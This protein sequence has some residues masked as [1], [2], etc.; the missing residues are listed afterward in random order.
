MTAKN[1]AFQLG[2]S[3]I[4]LG[5]GMRKIGTLLRLVFIIVLPFFLLSASIA[6]GFNSLWWYNFGF[7]KYHISE[8][9]GLSQSELNKAAQELIGYFNS[10]AELA[11]FRLTKDGQT[12]TLFSPQEQVHFKDVK[13]LVHL[14]YSVLIS[15][16]I[17]ALAFVGF[18]IWRRRDIGWS[19]LARGLMAGS[20]L[21]LGLIAVVGLGILFDFEGLFLQFHKLVFSNQFWSAPG[22]MLLLFPEGFWSDTAALLTAITAASAIVLGAAARCYL[23]KSGREN[24]LES[25]Q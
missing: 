19:D 23:K 7:Q 16:L 9:T 1:W 18:S 10:D 4:S 3:R 13:Q 20:G 6:W 15:T 22:Y 25:G 21:T 5:Y 12:F 8:A 14:D 24:H 11:D 17:L 2:K